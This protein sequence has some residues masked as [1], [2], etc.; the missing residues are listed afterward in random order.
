MSSNFNPIIYQTHPSPEQIKTAYE[1]C[2]GV[3]TNCLGCLA[4]HVCK[5]HLA[6]WMNDNER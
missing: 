6:V 4:Q 1:N 2:Q 5:D 3:S